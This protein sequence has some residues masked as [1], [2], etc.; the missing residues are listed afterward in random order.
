MESLEVYDNGEPTKDGLQVPWPLLGPPSSSREELA[1]DL[2]SRGI[3]PDW[4]STVPELLHLRNCGKQFCFQHM[5]NACN[6]V[7]PG[8]IQSLRQRLLDRWREVLGLTA[9]AITIK[10]AFTSDLSMT[11]KLLFR[12]REA[13]TD[14]HGSIIEVGKE[15]SDW[16]VYYYTIAIGGCSLDETISTTPAMCFSLTVACSAL[17]WLSNHLIRTRFAPAYQ[18]HKMNSTYL[19]DICLVIPKVH[20]R[21]VRTFRRVV[22]GV[23][24][25]QRVALAALGKF[26]SQAEEAKF[27]IMRQDCEK[28]TAHCG[29][30]QP[31]GQNKYEPLL[32]EIAV[33]DDAKA[34]V[35]T[36]WNCKPAERSSSAIMHAGSISHWLEN[37]RPFDYDV[38]IPAAWV[39]AGSNASAIAPVLFL[40]SLPQ[41]IEGEQWG[42]EK[43]AAVQ[44]AGWFGRTVSTPEQPPCQPPLIAN[45]VPRMQVQV[46]I[47]RTLRVEPGAVKPVF[48]AL[49]ETYRR[50]ETHSGQDVVIGYEVDRPSEFWTAPQI[51]EAWEAFHRLNPD[52]YGRRMVTGS[53]AKKKSKRKIDGED[54]TIEGEPAYNVK[55]HAA[56][57]Q[58]CQKLFA[59]QMQMPMKDRPDISAAFDDWK[60]AA[61]ALHSTANKV[62]HCITNRAHPDGSPWSPRTP[63]W[64]MFFRRPLYTVQK[65]G[66]INRHDYS[67]AADQNM[68]GPQ[69][70][71]AAG[72]RTEAGAFAA[73]AAAAAAGVAGGAHV[74]VAADVRPG[75][76]LSR[77]G[78]AQHASQPAKHA[79]AKDNAVMRAELQAKKEQTDKKRKQKKQRQEAK[80]RKKAKD[81]ATAAAAAAAVAA[82]ADL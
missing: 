18:P 65:N 60:I 30:K 67:A 71:T 81:A 57:L 22:N 47:T 37:T 6:T 32:T 11:T 54:V 46:H 82:D 56:E 45:S 41:L 14:E 2:E 12:W 9:S 36:V 52:I 5:E 16:W 70:R 43:F 75:A 69:E 35:L 61:G 55:D 78:R 25:V 38:A 44:G 59:T 28:Y 76:R 66:H 40:E 74:A 8:E 10:D 23:V 49:K 24:F 50:S 21:G 17:Y 20:G 63:V 73:M 34:I 77:A 72:V 48:W 31:D 64:G 42:Q 29:G 80:T 33:R 79:P 13:T 68:A 26:H 4:M 58:R 19:H 27:K 39:E 3:F 15:E 51:N 7:R 1:R 62:Q 53:G